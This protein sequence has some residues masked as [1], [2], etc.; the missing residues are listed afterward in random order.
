MPAPEDHVRTLQAQIRERLDVLRPLVP[1]A[2][3]YARAAAHVLEATAELIEYEERLP[4]LIDEPRHRLS[5][6]AVRW[7]GLVTA[8]V[9]GMLALACL[10]GW[11]ASWGLVLLL[12]VAVAGLRMLRLPVQP[13]G[14]PHVQQR[15]GALVVAA[16][17]P[18]TVLATS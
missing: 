4:F 10:P 1:D 5:V 14:G 9:A 3:G 18:V 6:A 16:S 13:A 15:N 17:S 12:P 11:V 7:S 2:D 8:A